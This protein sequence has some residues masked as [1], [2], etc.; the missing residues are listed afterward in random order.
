MKKLLAISALFLSAHSFGQAFTEGFNDLFDASLTSST[1]A[2]ESRGWALLNN[3]TIPST[4]AGIKLFANTGWF[5]NGTI[6]ASNAGA[7]YVAGNTDF[8]ALHGRRI[9]KA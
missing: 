3:S 6:F 2:L 9:N 5:G 7:G 8:D 4:P 1:T